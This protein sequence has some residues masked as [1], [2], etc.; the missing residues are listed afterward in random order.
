MSTSNLGTAKGSKR[1]LVVLGDRSLSAAVSALPV[2]CAIRSRWPD[3]HLS[4]GHFRETQRTVFEMC[5][6]ISELVRLSNLKIKKRSFLERCWRALR[7]FLP[8]LRAMRGYDT[9]ALL[10]AKDSYWPM[11]VLARLA[12][13][14]V[15]HRGMFG[16]LYWPTAVFYENITRQILNADPQSRVLQRLPALRVRE[17]DK[18]WA[19][20]FF[21]ANHL[22]GRRTLFMNPYRASKH[23]GWGFK[24]YI[25]LAKTLTDC[26]MSVVM[27]EDG[28]PDQK[29]GAGGIRDMAELKGLWRELGEAGVIVA[30]TIPTRQMIAL[31]NRCDMTVGEQSGPVWI[32]AA[33]GKPTVTIASS[34]DASVASL[35]PSANP[36]SGISSAKH[37]V[38]ISDE[39]KPVREDDF[40]SMVLE[41]L[42]TVSDGYSDEVPYLELKE[43][44]SIVLE[45]TEGCLGGVPS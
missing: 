35:L 29:L 44:T 9:I 38:F 26:G 33:L 32:A 37:T 39:S 24:R 6:Q 20:R 23:E 42:R 1:V 4:V 30:G 11:F 17:E 41:K 8:V 5:P 12:A 21:A 28:G 43:Q 2:F 13:K 19:E 10:Q 18:E 27:Q 31:V 15:F 16:N 7:G 3:V 34:A 22:V 25:Q 36:S 45:A 14:E 40:A